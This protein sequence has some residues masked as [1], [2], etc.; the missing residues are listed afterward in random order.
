M[1]EVEDLQREVQRL[2][3]AK[4]RALAIADERAKE[5]CG[6]RQEVERLRARLA[7][8]KGG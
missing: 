7:E 5:A 1:S 4:R 2:Q 6:L 3:E 8:C